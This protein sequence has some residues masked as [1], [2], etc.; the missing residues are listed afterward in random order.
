MILQAEKRS[1]LEE[2]LKLTR[3][4]SSA[5]ICLSFFNLILAI[6]LSFSFFKQIFRD[7]DA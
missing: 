4:L 5:I 1:F 7:L 2:K 3:V 6:E